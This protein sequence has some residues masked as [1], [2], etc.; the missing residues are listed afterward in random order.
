MEAVG[1]LP[2]PGGI[3]FSVKDSDKERAAQ[4]AREFASM[5]FKPYATEGTH[6]FLEGKGIGSVRLNKVRQGHPHVVDALKNGEIHVVV[7]TVTNSEQ[8]IADSYSIRRTS[9]QKGVV[10]FTTI[11]GA[12]AAC[13]A[14]AL[15][16]DRKRAAKA[17]SLQEWC[18]PPGGDG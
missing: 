3:L 11:D 13:Q 17:C 14:I 7:N 8:T 6:T 12:D 1:E 16:P 5:G 4:I 2:Q 15:G 9:L 18:R 10:Y